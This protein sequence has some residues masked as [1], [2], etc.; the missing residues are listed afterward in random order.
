MRSIL[1]ALGFSALLTSLPQVSAASDGE[2][3][4][5]SQ[6]PQCAQ[7]CGPL[8]DVQGKCAPPKLSSV[9]KSC[10]C[11]DSRLAGFLKQSTVGVC[12]YACHYNDLLSIQS[13][14]IDYCSKDEGATS[15]STSTTSTSTESS[16]PTGTDVEHA[17]N[18]SETATTDPGTT[19]GQIE[20]HPPWYFQT[21]SQPFRVLG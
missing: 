20:E 14:V 3:V 11:S 12:D 21:L 15:T 18:S 9:D 13:W 8:Y 4:Q 1:Y 5:F 7:W 6:L 10:F 19:K 2:I 17:P 16:T